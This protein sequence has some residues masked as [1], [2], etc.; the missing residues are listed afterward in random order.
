MKS[1]GTKRHNTKPGQCKAWGHP[2]KGPF[3][4]VIPPSKKQIP[5]DSS[6]AKRLSGFYQKLVDFSDMSA[7]SNPQ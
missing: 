3:Y 4:V 7:K 1:I 6:K 2:L 5:V